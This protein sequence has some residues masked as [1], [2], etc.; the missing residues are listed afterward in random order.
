MTNPATANEFVT[1]VDG[2]T[3]G[4]IYFWKTST[5][6]SHEALV[7]VM[8]YGGSGRIW[9]RRFVEKL[10]QKYVVNHLRQPRYGI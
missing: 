7:L 3:S 6:T 10:A 4:G 8:G 2:K 1:D 9:P 5:S